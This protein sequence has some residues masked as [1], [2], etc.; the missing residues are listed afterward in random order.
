[1]P[2]QYI[3]KNCEILLSFI[4]KFRL[5]KGFIMFGKLKDYQ[6]NGQTIDFTFE[7]NEA[8]VEII[9]DCIIRVFSFYDQEHFISK[10]IEENKS[11]PVEFEVFRTPTEVVITTSSVII[12]VRD[13]FGVDFYDKNN[14][15]ISGEYAGI[16]SRKSALSKEAAALLK[17]EGHNA[18]VGESKDYAIQTVRTLDPQ[19]CIYGLGDKTGVLNKRHYEYE[20]WNTDEPAPHEDCFKS[21][22]KSIP[23]MINLKK[24]GVYGIFLDNTYRTYF[25]MGKESSEYYVLGS[26]HGNLDYYYIAGEKMVDIIQRYTYLTGTYPLPQ[27]WTLGYHQSRWGYDSETELRNIADQMR[28]NQ[29]PCDCLHFDIDYMDHYKV[30]TWN[31]ET[32]K[33]PEKLVSDL[34]DMGIKVVTIIDPGVKVEKG[35]EIY[36]TGM[37]KGYFAKSSKGRTY[38]NAVWPGSSVFPD[39]GNPKV[40]NW[41]GDNHRFLLDK[42]VSG[43]WNDMN[44]PASFRGPLPDDVVFTDETVPSTHKAMHN[45]YGHLMAKA[46][47]EGLKKY[48]GKRPFVITRACYSG[49]QKYSTFWT[50]DNCSLWTHLRMSIP[51]LCN[52]GLSGL[53]FVGCDIGGF[54]ADCTPELMIRWIQAGCFSPFFRNHSAQGTVRQEPWM[55]GEKVM[56]IYRSFVNLR[57]Q[58]IPYYYDLFHDEEKNGLPLMRPLVLHYETDEN[59]KNLNDEFL[60]GENLLVAPVVEQGVT[61]RMVYLPEGIW[62]DYFTKERLQGGTYY[63]RKAPLE[64]CPVFVKAGTILPKYPNQNYIGEKII[65]EITFEIYPG[66]GSYHH[67]VDNGEDFG[68]RNG[69]YTEYLIT[70]SDDK[71]ITT[72][73]LKDGY[74]LYKDIHFDFIVK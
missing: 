71:T 66:A 10:A 35:Y 40:R 13:N 31:K 45:V 48:S 49:S 54:G 36:E 60:I 64:S 69:E 7:E 38:V 41:W 53:P 15:L 67:Y 20:M 3:I 74:G 68:Y 73:I 9:T 62:Y 24:N 8:S 65:D 21:L 52:M 14:I 6:L 16:R 61:M 37:K 28:Q 72:S 2:Y 51:Q 50:G 29:I 26:D 59:V 63:L 17:E 5:S 70:L 22:Y 57:Y 46:T 44:E 27:M 34:K 23:F 19:D 43:I 30:F 12:K 32:H 47:Y 55:F 11:K 18:D 25:N 1:M 42:G 39:F 56:D 58:L 4:T 33:N